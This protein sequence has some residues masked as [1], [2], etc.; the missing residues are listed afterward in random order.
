MPLY[1]FRCADC[2]RDQDQFARVDDRDA[3]PPVCCGAAMARQLVAPMVS[4]SNTEAYKCP[5]TGETVS[6][7]RRR[8]RR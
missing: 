3:N 1:P 2:G 4:V 7:E 5:M 8:P 6:S